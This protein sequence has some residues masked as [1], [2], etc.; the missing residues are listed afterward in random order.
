MSDA[1]RHFPDDHPSPYLRGVRRRSV[2]QSKRE[3]R[4]RVQWIEQKLSMFESEQIRSR[5]GAVGYLIGEL[6]AIYVLFEAVSTE[7][8]P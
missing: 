1:H 7:D 4:R 5:E 3:L 6:A 2:E 8:T